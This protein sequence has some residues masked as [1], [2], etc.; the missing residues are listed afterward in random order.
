MKLIFI[1]GPPAS[2]KLTVA[3]ELSKLTRIPVFHNHLTRDLVQSIYGDELSANYQLVDELR[4]NVFEYC[5]QHKTDLIFTFVYDGPED[6]RAVQDKIDVIRGN[7]GEVYF[8]ELSAPHEVLI[9]RV[10]DLSRFEHKKLTDK[11]VLSKL[12]ISN[13]YSS[14]P[15]ENILRIDTNTLT[16]QEA[17]DH[18]SKALKL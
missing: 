13:P 16:A 18:I 10:S 1:Y 5:A 11:E 2:G 14:V 17:A 9:T 4:N 8:V 3:K 6:D 7:G 12:L 15:Y